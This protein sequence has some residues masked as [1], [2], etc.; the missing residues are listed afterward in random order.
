M[1]SR[2]PF[3]FLALWLLLPATQGA[4]ALES[5]SE[6]PMYIEA[7]QVEVREEQGLSL[8]AGNVLITQGSLRLSADEVTVHHRED[9]RPRQII[10]RGAPARLSQRLDN[11]EDELQAVARRMEYDVESDTLTLIEQAELIQGADRV[12][13]ERILYDRARAQFRAGG[14]GRVRITLTPDN[15]DAQASEA[16]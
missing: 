12:S 10:A 2:H 3:V 5:D 11:S 7:D 14:G 15:R 1:N 4:R 16:P 6:Q 9:R 8:Y 13:G